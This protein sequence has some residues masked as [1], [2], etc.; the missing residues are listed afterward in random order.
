MLSVV[1]VSTAVT[2]L[3]T[4][5]SIIV[6]I[7][8]QNAHVLRQGVLRSHVGLVVGI[9]IISDI[10]LI[11]AGVSGV[12]TVVQEH[13]VAIP[14]LRWGGAAYLAGYGLRSLWAARRPQAL[15]AG[16]G[17]APSRRLVAGTT[18]ALTYLNPHLYVD[19]LMLASIA[20]QYGAERWWFLAGTLTASA[21]WFLGLGYG[22]KAA[23]RVL[24]RPATWRVLDL[25]IGLLMIVLAI[26]LASG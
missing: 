15:E 18:L 14:V 4:G 10:L 6:A 20:N 1:G 25:T 7:G 19:V 17:A 26:R 12:A 23:S 22:A 21:V 8:A 11:T 16:E 2:G 5:L 13:P 3:L 24:A 9:C